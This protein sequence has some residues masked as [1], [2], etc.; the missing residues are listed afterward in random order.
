[1]KLDTSKIVTDYVG[2]IFTAATIAIIGAI[3]DVQF[4]KANV[5]DIRKEVAEDRKYNRDTH[6][7]TCHLAIQN[8]ALSDQEK[9][10]FCSG[11]R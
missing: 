2:W 5:H 10:N 9:A 3:I 7:V 1:M 11:V 8:K 4:L 6:K